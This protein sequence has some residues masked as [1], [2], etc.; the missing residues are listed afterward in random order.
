MTDIKYRLVES[1]K[2][3]KGVS[4]RIDKNGELEVRVP[5]GFSKEIADR[6]VEHN[7]ALIERKL[8]EYGKFAEAK[9]Y[10]TIDYG[11]TVP[12]LGKE[13]AVF[14]ESDAES[15]S[16]SCG[17]DSDVNRKNNYGDESD[18]HGA[19]YCDEAKQN[20][21]GKGI[22][23]DLMI[24]ECGCGRFER[25]F[26]IR[27]G[28]EPV[29]VERALAGIYA[30]AARRYLPGRTREIAGKLGTECPSVRINGAKKQWGS[31]THDRKHGDIRISYSWRVML[32][33]PR[34]VDSVIVHELC[35]IEDANHG[36]RFWRHVKN[37]MP[38]YPQT[39]KELE[40]L[41]YMMARRWHV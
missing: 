10:Y 24:A 8:A 14:A 30:A 40:R 1:K 34:A 37:F 27:K 39:H 25:G 22:D 16:D 23:P 11:M 21:G 33:S 12:M 15:A 32:A 7:R 4:L 13:Y 20:D 26:Y 29:E 3:V 38:D 28:F 19:E 17:S 6:I 9:S 31:C 5:V 18:I 36:D 2:A 35:H 41:A